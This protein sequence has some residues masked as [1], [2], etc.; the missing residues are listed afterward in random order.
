MS[1]HG[2]RI[3]WDAG[4]EGGRSLVR[5]VV[6]IAF[7]M[8]HD[9][10]ELAPGIARALEVYRNALDTEREGLTHGW[11]SEGE[12][13][14][15]TPESWKDARASLLPSTLFRFLEEIH[16]VPKYSESFQRMLKSQSETSLLLTG[17][18]L[19][20]RNGFELRYQARLPWREPPE[21]SVSVLSAT[22]PMEYV[23]AQG[24]GRVRE[25][26]ME[27]ASGL[28]I[29]SGH[30]GLAL[31]LAGPRGRLLARVREELMRHP[32]VDVPGV[33]TPITLGARV[34]GIHWLNFLGPSLLAAVGGVASLRARLRSPG[35][36]VQDVGTS[37]TTV[38]TLGAWPEAGDLSQ[39]KDLPAYRELARV[40]EPWLEDFR[41]S[42]GLAWRGYLEEDVRR[43]WRRF[44]D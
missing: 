11:D 9:H 4:S 14:V 39:R 36:T 34:D 30:V 29:A 15:L 23:E 1:E 19:S 35:T 25:L 6:R 10:H 20:E 24:P 33:D 44:L 37:G 22:L 18:G 38:V 40:L 21:G 42:H 16:D 2:P 32:G 28:R 12:P 5:E 26:A 27:L 43:W 31:A 8:P 13:F 17:G 7:Y 41:P 3:R